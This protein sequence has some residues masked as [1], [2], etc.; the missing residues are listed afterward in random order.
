MGSLRERWSTSRCYPTWSGDGIAASFTMTATSCTEVRLPA[1]SGDPCAPLLSQTD[2]LS[3]V[4]ITGWNDSG[5]LADLIYLDLSTFKARGRGR[6][7]HVLKVEILT[8]LGIRNAEMGS[9]QVQGDGAVL[10]PMAH[11]DAT[12]QHQRPLLPLWRLQWRH[13][14][15]WRRLSSQH[16][17]PLYTRA[18]SCPCLM[19]CVPYDR[20]R[21]YAPSDT[22][23]WSQP[24]FKG[25]VPGPRCRH[26]MTAVDDKQL[27]LLGGYKE[28]DN[29]IYKEIAVLHTGAVCVDDEEEG[30]FSR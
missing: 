24:R 30:S 28:S 7:W 16:W 19:A 1:P 14:A 9:A 12:V 8:M 15:P 29:A 11:N 17:Y 5:G 25:K 22:Q 27:V 20:T 23:T 13:D 18:T 26:T 2:L 21:A 3:T 4:I 6:W 10:P